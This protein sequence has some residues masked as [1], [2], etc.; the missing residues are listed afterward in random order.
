MKYGERGSYATLNWYS[1][2]MNG[3]DGI[4]NDMNEPAVFRVSGLMGRCTAAAKVK[5]D[6]RCTFVALNR[7]SSSHCDLRSE[8]D[9][10]RLE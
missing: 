9:G 7:C 3:V 4:W 5:S 8:Q 2:A 10:W 1:S 6:E